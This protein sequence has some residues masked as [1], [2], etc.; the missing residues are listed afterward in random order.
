M[1]P[2]R[3]LGS[4]VITRFV[5]TMGRSDSRTSAPA[6]YLFPADADLPCCPVGRCGP[7]MFLNALSDRAAL[8]DPGEPAACS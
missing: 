1:L 2:L 3:P 7:L 4:T 8:F 5:A 6:G